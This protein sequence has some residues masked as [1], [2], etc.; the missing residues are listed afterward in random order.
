MKK[1]LSL[2]LTFALLLALAACGGTGGE[3]SAPDATA[4]AADSDTAPAEPV[5]LKALLES[6]QQSCSLDSG[7]IYSSYS[8]VLGEYMDEEMILGKYGSQSPAPDFG[9]Y[10]QYAIYFGFETYQDEV[11]LFEVRDEADIETTKRF[12]QLRIDE[13][14][15]NAVNYPELDTARLKNAVI[16][17]SGSYV[18]CIGGAHR[19][20]E[21]ARLNFEGSV[22]TYGKQPIQQ[23]DFRHPARA[24]QG[25]PLVAPVCN[26]GGHQL[27]PDAE[28][29]AGH[30]GEPAAPQAD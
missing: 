2:V 22:T 15:A 20:R 28:A 3:S 16:G 4:S 8:D 6:V 11:A 27:C 5:N 10:A 13:L 17:S 18:Y 14:L 30:A 9:V 1:S 26:R 19:R 25:R 24:G 29:G 12:L 7:S 21:R 23:E